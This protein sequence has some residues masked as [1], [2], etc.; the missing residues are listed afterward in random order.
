VNPAASGEFGVN[1]VSTSNYT[2][3]GYGKSALLPLVLSNG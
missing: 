3:R 2:V 1:P